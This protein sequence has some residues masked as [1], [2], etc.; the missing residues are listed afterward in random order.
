MLMLSDVIAALATPPGRSALALLRVSGRGCFDVVRR[1]IPEFVAEPARV[2]RLARA[3]NTGG[4]PIDD[5]LYTAFQAP[6]S[7]TGED[8][9]EI[10]THGGLLNPAEVLAALFVAGAREA[11]PGEFTRRAMQHGKMDLLQAEATAD[12]ID[13]TAPAQRRQALAQLDRGL[14]ARIGALR[15]AVLGLEALVSYDIDFPEE[16]SGPV[17]PERIAGASADVRD[18]LARLLATAGEGERLREGAL[19]VI[20]GVPNAGK[21]ALFNALLGAER[22]IV[23]EIPGTTRDAIEAP[24]VLGGFPFRL[25]D[26]AGLRESTDRVE[27]LGIEVSRRYLGAADAVIFCAEAG[28]AL[29]DEERAFLGEARVPVVVVRTKCDL[30]P[31][32]ASGDREIATSAE[33]G[34]GIAELRDELARIAFATLSHGDPAPVLTRERHRAALGRALEEMDQF[35]AARDAGIE[36]AVAAT[37]L[38]AAV[39]A[40]EDVIGLI[41]TDDVLDRLFSSFCVGK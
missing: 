9:V 18:S 15:D 29:T 11:A 27:R 10:S 41:T 37:H 4:E 8:V 28:R 1:V 16:D 25:V 13:A 22:A 36:G 26:T 38:R 30:T 39:L 2:A 23:T 3:V 40:L 7:Y 32:D 14:T 17:P 35:A 19:A 5:V 20:A 21:S 33:S 31:G 6:A 24:A 12:L 34:V